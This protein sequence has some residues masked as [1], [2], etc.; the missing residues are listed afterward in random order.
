MHDMNSRRN[1][2]FPGRRQSD[3]AHFG[4]TPGLDS[5]ICSSVS[6]RQPSHDCQL[7]WSSREDALQCDHVIKLGNPIESVA[8]LCRSLLE[9][10]TEVSQMT[11]TDQLQMRSSFRFFQGRIRSWT[12]FVRIGMPRR[13]S[14]GASARCPGL[15]LAVAPA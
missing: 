14:K 2:S 9:S 11:R 7:P 15:A 8:K 10:S 4:T 12:D 5:L 13:P 3:K 1:I 6:T